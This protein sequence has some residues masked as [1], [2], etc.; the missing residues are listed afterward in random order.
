MGRHCGYLALSTAI[1]TSADWVFI[2]EEPPVEGWED[3]MC[4]KLEASR[5][6]GNRLNIIIVA[7]GAIDRQ[8]KPITTNYIKDRLIFE[9]NDHVENIFPLYFEFEPFIGY[10]LKPTDIRYACDSFR[11]CSARWASV[12]VWPK[13]GH[14]DGL[15]IR[16][17][18]LRSWAWIWCLCYSPEGIPPLSYLT[19]RL[20]LWPLRGHRVL[21]SILENNL[22]P[23]KSKMS[24]TWNLGL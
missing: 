11:P 15:R 8:G 19:P 13:F 17:G 20:S 1:A 23:T 4:K 18:A 7:E 24:P 10:M 14:T 5:E 16:S 9:N 6:Y 12:S 22:Q 2:P 21:K 3:I